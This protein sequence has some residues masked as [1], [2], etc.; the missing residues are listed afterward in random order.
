[1]AVEGLPQGWDR[2][3]PEWPLPGEPGTQAFH[4]SGG[5]G[6]YL[7]YLLAFSP[8]LG[9]FFVVFLLLGSILFETIASGTGMTGGIVVGAIATLCLAVTPVIKTR[10]MIRGTTVLTSPVGVELRDHI[11]FQVRLRWPDVVQ[12]DRT[13]DRISAGRGVEVG[14]KNVQVKDL[15]SRGLIGW[16]ERVV[17]DQAARM[18]QVFAAQPRHPRTGAE[19]VAVSFQAA[20]ADGWDNPLVLEARRHRPVVSSSNVQGAPG[21]LPGAPFRGL[22]RT[23]TR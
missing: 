20:G 5:A 16:G 6:T 3:S 13:L 15:E 10:R 4:P 18:R 17:P 23:R 2:V 7:R 19:L 1:M 22:C 11:G 14:G 21:S 9:V 8:L 12:I